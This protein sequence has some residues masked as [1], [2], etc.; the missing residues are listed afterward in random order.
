[1]A[2]LYELLFVQGGVA[3]KEVRLHLV[4]VELL[5]ETAHQDFYM[6]LY[7]RDIQ[8]HFTWV[9]QSETFIYYDWLFGILSF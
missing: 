2:F 4:Y 5:G 7:Q 9:L 1:M 6:L 8:T 3:L